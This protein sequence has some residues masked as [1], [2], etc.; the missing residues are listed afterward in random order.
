MVQVDWGVKT[1]T[2]TELLY[3]IVISKELKPPVEVVWDNTFSN[4]KDEKHEH[5][6]FVNE[7]ISYVIKHF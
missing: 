4:E 3:K 2:F 7:F 5:V 1:S 6:W